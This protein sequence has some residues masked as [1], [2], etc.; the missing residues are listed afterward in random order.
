M[1]TPP[2]AAVLAILAV[3]FSAASAFD[4]WSLLLALGLGAGLLVLINEEAPPETPPY[5]LEHRGSGDVRVL[6]TAQDQGTARARLRAQAA[7]LSADG[8]SG[9]LVLVD[10]ATGR[11]VSWQVLDSRVEDSA[12]A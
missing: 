6:A 5:R 7:R 11:V 2:L 1:R 8:A 12:A 9:Q 4:G 3:V 10:V